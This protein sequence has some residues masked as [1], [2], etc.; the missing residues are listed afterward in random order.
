MPFL[1]L[2]QMFLKLRFVVTHYELLSGALLL[3]LHCVL[4]KLKYCPFRSASCQ[5][6]RE[7][8]IDASD[9]LSANH[10]GHQQEISAEIDWE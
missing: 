4:R 2:L 7:R 6:E 9:T 8:K 3:I 1:T 5:Y 10:A